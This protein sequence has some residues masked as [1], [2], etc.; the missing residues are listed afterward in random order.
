MLLPSM[1]QSIRQEL[2][3]PGGIS[4]IWTDDELIRGI[5]KCVSL[6]SRHIPKKTMVETTIVTDITAESLTIVNDRGTA[7][8]KPIKYNSEIIRNIAGVIRIRDTDY[9]INYLTGAVTEKGVG[10][11][12]G[13]YTITYTL[14]KQ[15]LNL[16]TLLPDYI[17]IERV[18]YPVGDTPATYPPYDVFEGFIVLRGNNLLNEN[19]HLRIVYLGKWTPPTSSL[20]GDYPSHLND[21]LIIGAAGQAL[22]FKAEKY[23]QLA[24]NAL[25]ILTPPVTYSVVKP[26][27]PVG[28]SIIRP[29]AP[30]VYPV[31]KPTAPAG[32][33]ITT[34][35]A[36]AVYPVVKPTAPNIPAIAPPTV[37]PRYTLTFVEAIRVLNKVDNLAV[38]PT[39]ALI[40]ALSYLTTG[41]GLIN[42]ATVGERVGETYGGYGDVAARVA[43]NYIAQATAYIIEQREQLQRYASEVTAYGNEV[44]AYANR[45]N[46]IVGEYRAAM[47]IEAVG[48]DNYNAQVNRYR[49]DV[50]IQAAG[51][52]NYNTRVNEYRAAMDIEAVGVNNFAAQVDRYRADMDIEAVGVNNYNARV[53]EYRAAMDI[54][55]AGVNNFAAQVNRYTAQTAEQEMKVRNYLDIA[56]RYLASGQAKINEFLLALGVKAELQPVMVSS[57]QPGY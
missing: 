52:S 54:E 38:S 55:V 22:I 35:V 39:G 43:A 1:I 57:K 32:F 47:D 36:P 9:T 17:R 56:G 40:T 13:V 19:K 7:A 26:I 28:Y 29:T 50:D 34:P 12:D 33:L 16:S 5:T 46:G 31:V 14:D 48:V 23:V 45:I 2:S 11:P 8:N 37:P 4:P 25:S 27:A 21:V 10:L 20:A 30:A 44:T 42:V 3:D 18:E 15:M 41:A 51:I 6:M 24:I 53:N 49:T